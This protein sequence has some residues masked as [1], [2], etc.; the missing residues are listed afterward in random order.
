LRQL[1]R[2]IASICR[3]VAR[4]I[5]E[6]RADPVNVTTTNLPDFLGPPRTFPEESLRKDQIGVATA[7]AW[8]P[9]GGDVLFIEALLMAGHGSLILTGQLGDIMKESAQAALSWA[10][11]RATHFG[12]SQDAFEKHDIHIHVPE[13]AIP[14][15]GPSAGVALAAALVSALS[16]R[17]LKRSVALTGEITLRGSVLPVGA[18]KEKVLAARRARL[19]TVILPQQNRPDLEGLPKPILKEIN[20]VFVDSIQQAL[21]AALAPPKK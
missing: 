2:E 7:L 14:K 11:S 17:P 20:F 5:A 9:T 8:T 1:E 4:R 21:E 16:G 6:G 3:K 18:I 19:S 15:D 13:G 12:I 10:K